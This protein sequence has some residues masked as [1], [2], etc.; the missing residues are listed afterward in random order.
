M[1]FESSAKRREKKRINGVKSVMWGENDDR[2]VKNWHSHFIYFGKSSIKFYFCTGWYT[3][4]FYNG[5]EDSGI[6]D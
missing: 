5:R 3:N 2:G 1:L 4:S 6:F